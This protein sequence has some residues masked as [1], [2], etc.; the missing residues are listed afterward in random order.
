MIRSSRIAPLCFSCPA[1]A[2]G[3]QLEEAKSE[4]SGLTSQDLLQV[5]HA[6][7]PHL[8]ALLVAR[9]QLQRCPAALPATID[10]PSIP[11]CIYGILFRN[12]T[13]FIVAHIPYLFESTYRYHSL[14]VDRLPFPPYIPDDRHGVLARLR[15][16]VA[17]LTIR[18]H[19][20]RLASLWEDVIWPSTIIDADLMLVREC[21]GIITPS[22]SEYKDPG[23]LYLP[24]MDAHIGLASGHQ[25]WDINATPSEMARSK[26]LVEA[27]LPGVTLG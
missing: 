22:P 18:N 14:L 6:T 12:A 1:L 4:P 10:T 15:I 26:E 23:A 16:I 13:V 3:I 17:L 19:A 2:I 9:H 24:D 8:E 21:T 11:H 7:Q 5:A 27:W 20:D 25:E